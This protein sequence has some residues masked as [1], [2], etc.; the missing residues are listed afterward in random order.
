LANNHYDLCAFVVNN[1]HLVFI[2]LG[3][4]MGD[5]L[6]NL[7][8]ALRSMPPAIRPLAQSPIYETSPWGFTDQP[9][10]LNQVILAETDLAPQQLLDQLKSI[11]VNLGRMPTF[12]YGPRLIDLD[13]L[14]Y[15][16]LV[17]QTPHLTIPHPRLAERLF[18]LAPMADLAPDLRHPVL[19][20]TMRQL[21]EAVQS[22]GARRYN[23]PDQ[24]QGDN[25]RDDEH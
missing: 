22:Q 1:F 11:E 23:P 10:Y 17:L 2:A 9:D 21:L 25:N 3:S 7:Q 8:A 5:R 13:I 19:G 24:G 14:F 16:D 20:Q 15:D 6:E 4:N 18:V 12:H